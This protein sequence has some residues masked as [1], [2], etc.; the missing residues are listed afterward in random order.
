VLR[1]LNQAGVGTTVNYRAVHR[2]IYYQ[3]RYGHAPDAF[4]VASDWGDRT[5][6]LPLYPGLADDE[7]DYVIECVLD[8]VGHD[9]RPPATA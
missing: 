1:T 7:Q 9:L 2:M 3:N 5:L 8:A 4:P 6:S